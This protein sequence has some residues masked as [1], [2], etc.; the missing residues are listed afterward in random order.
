MLRPFIGRLMMYNCWDK[1]HDETFFVLRFYRP[2]FTS[3]FCCLYPKKEIYLLFSSFSFCWYLPYHLYS[4]SFNLKSWD[5]SF[6]HETHALNTLR[7]TWFSKWCCTLEKK[8]YCCVCVYVKRL[9]HS[10]NTIKDQW[11]EW[12]GNLALNYQSI[13]LI[14]QHLYTD[15]WLFN[16]WVLIIFTIWRIIHLS[17]GW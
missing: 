14:R 16:S 5:M 6:S 9:V 15:K 8:S 3:V 7:D 4:L 1:Y 11:V 13:P 17:E 12:L 10:V 2:R